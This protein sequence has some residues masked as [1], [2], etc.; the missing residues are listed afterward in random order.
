MAE[1]EDE[2]VDDVLREFSGLQ[3]YRNTFA[4]MWEETAELIAP[5]YR[6]TFFFGA[7]NF[8]GQKKTERQIDT[9]ATLALSRFGAILD[10]MLTPQ[11]AMW[12]NLAADDENLMKQ[13]AVKLYFEA[14]NRVLFKYRYK[15]TANFVSQNQGVFQQLGA[16]G[17]GIMYIDAYQG[18]DG[19]R[20]LRYRNNPLG[21]MFFRQNHQGQVDAYIRWFRYTRRQAILEYGEAALPETIVAATD[22]E[23]L[24][25][26]VQRVRPNPN[27]DPRRLDAKGKRWVSEHVALTGRKLVRESGYNTFPCAITRYTQ[28]NGQE[29]YGRGPAQQA[30]PTM[31]TSNSAMQ[32]YLTQSHR[33]I[34]PPLLTADDGI[35]DFSFRPGA[36]NKGGVGKDGRPLVIPLQGGNIQISEELL[37]KMGQTIDAFFLVDLFKILLDDPKIYSATQVVEM[38]SQ[39]GVLLAP[40]IGRQQSEYLGSVIPRE[41]DLLTQLRLLPQ[42]PPVLKE[43]G[44]E[45]KIVYTSPLARSMRA[46]DI[47]GLNRSLERAT[48]VATATGDPSPLW[49]FDWTTIIPEAADID[50]VPAHW[51]A[52]DEAVAAKAKAHQDMM[53]KQQQIQVAPAQAAIMKAQAA[54]QKAGVPQAAQG[55]GQ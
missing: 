2:I 10:S 9:K 44:G 33:A 27:R 40:T 49:H 48:Q 6:N 30:L 54:Q 41:I 11:N 37:D 32:D 18:N 46:S 3:T 35:V 21:E 12:H 4:G 14:V 15:T 38:M 34:A 55:Q 25:D 47:A 43:A 13:R 53:A 17:N 26:F 19:G 45:Y 5:D 22:S 39:R 16:F 51:L 28:I 24:Y 23:V 8:P 52:S 50:G 7:Y 31:K 36:L 1:R 42:M 29:V 20:G